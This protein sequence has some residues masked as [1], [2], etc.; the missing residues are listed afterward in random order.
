M[1]DP[2]EEAA[3]EGLRLL[4]AERGGGAARDLRRVGEVHAEAGD[5]VGDAA[6]RRQLRLGEHAAGL[7]LA[8][9]QV[10]RPFEPRLGPQ[11][12]GGVAQRHGEEQRPGG[13]LAR[14]AGGTEQRGEVEV[15]G[16]R[17]PHAHAAPAP[18]GLTPRE[19]REALRLALRGAH[20]GEVL[21]ARQRLLDLKPPRADRPIHAHGP[22]P[23]GDRAAITRPAPRRRCAPRPAPRRGRGRTAR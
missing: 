18:R 13:Q 7:G 11:R 2:V 23:A 22:S 21:G 20:Q 16:P 4:R 8:E 3:G 9:Q 12:G 1:H 6:L 17:I 14:R 15:A 10:V 5:E 19:D